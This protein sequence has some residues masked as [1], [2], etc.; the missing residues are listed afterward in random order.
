MTCCTESPTGQ[1]TFW[2]W[3]IPDLISCAGV[4]RRWGLLLHAESAVRWHGSMYLLANKIRLSFV[5]HRQ[6]VD[7]CQIPRGLP[8]WAPPPSPILHMLRLPNLQLPKDHAG[9]VLAAQRWR[10]ILLSPLESMYVW[11]HSQAPLTSFPGHFQILSRSCGEKS[12]LH[13]YEIKSLGLIPRPLPDFIH[14]CELNCGSGLGMRPRLPYNMG[15]S[16]AKP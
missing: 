8:V 16:E 15:G 9:S 14:S 13:S 5:Y 10:N 1:H 12:F 2:F 7:C 4:T 3:P 11:N 6:K